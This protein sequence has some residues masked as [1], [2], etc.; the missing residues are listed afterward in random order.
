[1]QRQSFLADLH[2]FKKVRRSHPYGRVRRKQPG[3]P[4][5]PGNTES[6]I[7]ETGTRAKLLNASP[8]LGTVSMKGGKQPI[9]EGSPLLSNFNRRRPWACFSRATKTE[10]FGSHTFTLSW[11]GSGDRFLLEAPKDRADAVPR[12]VHLIFLRSLPLISGSPAPLADPPQP[13]RGEVYRR[14]PIQRCVAPTKTS[15]SFRRRR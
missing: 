2:R 8:V 13:T 15:S 10:V 5:L 14:L 4:G 1:V 11:S 7:L 6:S 3:V 9:R 12:P